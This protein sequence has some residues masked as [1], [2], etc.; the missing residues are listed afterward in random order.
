[1]YASSW[2]VMLMNYEVVPMLVL[3]AVVQCGKVVDGE[4]W[5]SWRRWSRSFGKAI[6]EVCYIVV[7]LCFACLNSCQCE[8]NAWCE[9][10]CCAR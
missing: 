6:A 5:C 9:N 4:A 8:L 2:V 1:V 10:R 3:V 7:D